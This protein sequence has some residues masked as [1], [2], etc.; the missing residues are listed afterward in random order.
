MRSLEKVIH[1]KF[2]VRKGIDIS[3]SKRERVIQQFTGKPIYT[4]IIYK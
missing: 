3:Y 2:M 4:M 1:N